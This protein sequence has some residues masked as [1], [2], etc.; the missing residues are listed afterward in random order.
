MRLE[1]SVEAQHHGTTSTANIGRKPFVIASKLYDRVIRGSGPLRLGGYGSDHL[2][3]VHR[4]TPKCEIVI[5]EENRT[6]ED[7]RRHAADVW[8]QRAMSSCLIRCHRDDLA[9]D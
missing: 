2:W 1:C 8:G 5:F 3:F 4:N 6:S 9:H 7:V